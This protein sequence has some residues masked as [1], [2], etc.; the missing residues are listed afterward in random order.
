MR[1][2]LQQKLNQKLAPAQIQLMQ[3]IQI[4]GI[5]IEDRIMEE[6]ASNPALEIDN[7]K[8]EEPQEIET[9]VYDE[10]LPEHETYDELQTSSNEGEESN[11]NT[12]DY[13]EGH[14]Q[15]AIVDPF[16]TKRNQESFYDMLLQ[17]LDMQDL[18]DFQ[19]QIASYIIGNVDEDGYLRRTALEMSDDL[20]LKKI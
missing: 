7:S 11:Y 17:Q 5:D 3:L 12:Y 20:A 15:D 10:V 9:S 4:P 16:A 8:A 1:Q 13:Y 14:N 18:N 6:I 19:K 2:S